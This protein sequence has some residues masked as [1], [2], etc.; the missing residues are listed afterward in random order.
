M[1]LIYDSFAVK[2]ITVYDNVGKSNVPFYLQT[3]RSSAE[4]G[5]NQEHSG[6]I[7]QSETEVNRNVLGN[8]S[9]KTGDTS[10]KYKV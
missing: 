4:V 1:L 8:D 7:S 2:R 5:G 6:I 10:A 3:I 9:G